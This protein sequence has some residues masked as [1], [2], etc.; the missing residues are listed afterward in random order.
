MQKLWTGILGLAAL[1]ALGI[2]PA[3]AGKPD[4]TLRIAVVDWW[5]TLDPYQFPLDEAGVFYRGVYETLVRYDEREHKILPR[6]AKAWRQV[7]DKTVEFTLRDDVKF[8]NGDRFDADDVVDTIRFLIDPNTQIRFKDV[9]LWID[10]IEKVDPYKVRITAKEPFAGEL[11]AFAYRFYIYDSKVLNKLENKADYGRLGAIAT[12]PYKVVSLDQQKMVLTRF[13]DYYDKDR[14]GTAPIKNIVVMPIP[15]RQTQI[16]QFMTGNIDLIRNATADLARELA[17]DPDSRVTPMHNGLLMYL[18]LD[19]AGR[20]DNKVMM[21]QKV[22]KAVMEAIDRQELTKTVI[23][24]GQIAALLD[25]IC[26]PADIGCA[27]STKPP[28]YNPEDAK[29]LLAEAGYKDGFDLEFDVHEPL[30]EIG[31]AMAGM[32]RKVGIRATMRTL[33]LALYVRMRGEGK[34]TAFLGFYPT[35]AQPDMDNILD[36]F[37]DGNRDYWA[38][39]PIIKAA[40]KTG[41]IEGDLEKRG[42]IYKRA[43]DEVNNKNFILPVADLPMVFV[44]TK[45]VM[46]KENPITPI[47]TEVDDFYWAP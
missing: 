10:K 18:T 30:A 13:D 2:T 8:H 5:S 35:N 28:A 12:G 1:L 14:P 7:D 27:S 22:R 42:D 15:D 37:F 21:D 17:K 9:F 4:D 39:D 19:A 36:L 32:L 33:P 23:P 44:H 34:L 47:N 6:L 29:K 3:A 11:M 31:E 45:D 26:V 41:A 46:V 40:Q 25:G 24:G 16:A 20:S 43:I 38:A